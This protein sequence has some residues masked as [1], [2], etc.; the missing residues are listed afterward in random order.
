MEI[1]GVNVNATKEETTTA[2]AMTTLNSR[3]KRPVVPSKKTIGKNTATSTTV[4]AITAKKISFDPLNPACKGVIPCSIFVK[5]FSMTTMA[6]STTKPMAKTTANKVRML[7]GESGH[8]HDKERG[9]Q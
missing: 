5:M 7:M 2:P 8:V 6:S 3:N 4:V 9:D 1:I